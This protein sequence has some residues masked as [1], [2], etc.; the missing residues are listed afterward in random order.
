VAFPGGQGTPS[1]MPV[2]KRVYAQWVKTMV[3]EGYLKPNQVAEIAR[4][5]GAL[6]RGMLVQAPGEIIRLEREQETI[7]DEL[8]SLLDERGRI[9]DRESRNRGNQFGGDGSRAFANQPRGA[10][11]MSGA[12]GTYQTL[13][14]HIGC[15]TPNRDCNNN[16]PYNISCTFVK[17]DDGK[18]KVETGNITL[19]GDLNGTDYK[20]T[21]NGYG[22]GSFQFSPDF[23][24][25]TGTFEDKNGHRGTWTGNKR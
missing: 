20:F 1:G 17:M 14:T 18:I 25:F 11:I 23:S 9:R 4:I 22:W 13:H 21:Y 5:S 24:S 16:K 12:S 2:L 3:I 15:T 10:N 8:S 6:T 19:V 7:K